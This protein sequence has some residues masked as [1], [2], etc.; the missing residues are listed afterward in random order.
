MDS[1]SGAAIL[2]MRRVRSTRSLK[3]PSK[4]DRG[5]AF[6]LLGGADRHFAHRALEL[7]M[8]LASAI[9]RHA[10]QP[11][12][13]SALRAERVIDLGILNDGCLGVRHGTFPLDGQARAQRLSTTDAQVRCADSC[14]MLPT[15]YVVDKT[16]ESQEC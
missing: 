6:N 1:R 7:P 10:R 13:R 15:E 5:A 16:E 14:L 3:P 4:L 11:H 12:L 8:L 9:G 2:R